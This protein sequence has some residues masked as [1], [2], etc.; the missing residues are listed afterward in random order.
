MTRRRA[1]RKFWRL[2]IPLI[3]MLALGGCATTVS[4]PTV[5]ELSYKHLPSLNFSVERI[6]FVEKFISPLQSPHVEHLFPTPIVQAL[7]RWRDDR[8]Q[9][10]GGS[11][12]MR[13]IV[14]DASAVAE[15]L[16]TN[17]G[18][19]A[20]FTTEQAEK[21][22]ARIQVR[23][24]IVDGNG[25]MKAYTS[26]EAERSRTTPE[27]ITLNERDKIYNDLTMVLMN[28]FNASQEQGIR[29]YFQRYLN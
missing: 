8:L 16:E 7:K 23:I 9:A 29:L 21:V 22:D 18:L 15:E 10:V 27:N 13:I 25:K 2:A 26:T 12:V 14:E 5:P 11:D 19:E 28:D 20:W 1:G 24:E 6:E 4:R 3:G 17:E